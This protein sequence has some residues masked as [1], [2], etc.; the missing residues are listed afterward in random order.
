MP[1]IT[2]ADGSPMSSLCFGTMQFGGNADQSAAAAM[3]AACREAGVNFFDTAH[4]YSG[5]RSETILGQLAAD[6]RDALIIAT[7]VNFEDGMSAP[8][9]HRSVEESRQRLGM[10]TLDILYLHRWDDDVPLEESFEALATYVDN[11]TVR[12][13]G[14][15][16]Y[17]AWQVVKAQQVAAGFG[18]QIAILQPM[19]NLVKRQAEVEILPMAQSEGLAVAPYSPLG[20]GLLTG[21]YSAGE[22]GRLTDNS[23][24]AVRYGPRWMHDAA[25]GLAE[26]GAELCV[27]AATLAVAWCARHP[28]I[29]APIVSARSAKQLAPSLAA[30]SFE[31]DAALY[32]RISALSP[33]P[34]PATDRLEEAL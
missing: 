27:P 13:I 17:A 14:V 15:S 18:V 34:P 4:T 11:G 7:K 1:L 26:I 31:M 8:V 33:T 10:D 29:T 22:T 3:Y 28:G 32:A 23:G 2:A 25:A 6:E 12:H 20:G 19:Y 30:A 24:Y 5:G 16:N 21:K 9:V